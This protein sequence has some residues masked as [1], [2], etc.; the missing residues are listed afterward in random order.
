MPRVASLF[1]P[2]L[3]IE[4][5]RR[6]ERMR[7]MARSAAPPDAASGSRFA[8]AIDDDPG[9]CSVPRGGGWRPGARWARNEAVSG[10]PSQ[11]ALDALPAHQRPTMREMGRRSEHA[12]HPFKA[13]PSDEVGGA[14]SAPQLSWARLGGRPTVLVLR[15]GQRDVITAACPGAL[16]LG[17]RPGM[18]AAH[19]RS[20]SRQR[21]FWDTAPWAWPIAILWLASC[22]AGRARRRPASA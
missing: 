22:A 14:T 15:T 12:E 13:M 16:D 1:L 7:G 21:R 8:Q 5:L 17:L 2:H 20:C 10:R 11:A 3:A 6:V 4:R 18:V 9:A 19:P